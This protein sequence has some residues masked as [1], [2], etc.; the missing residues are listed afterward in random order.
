MKTMTRNSKTRR[1]KPAVEDAGP[2]RERLNC[3]L[4]GDDA[5]KLRE[6]RKLVVNATGDVASGN[7]LILT[8]LRALD[9]TDRERILELHAEVIAGDRRRRS[10]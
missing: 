8:A 9:L 10:S 1:A 2:E 4:T 3:Y 7:S 5:E 6:M